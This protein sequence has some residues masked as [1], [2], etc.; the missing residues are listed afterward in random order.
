MSRV[1][2]P[3]AVLVCIVDNTRCP[4]KAD[5][6]ANSAVS[7]SLISP[8]IIVSGSCRKTDRRPLA[9][10]KPIFSLIPIW[11]APFISA[12]TGSSRQIN[13]VSSRLSMRNMAYKVAVLPLPVGPQISNKP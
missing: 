2:T 6:T 5:L 11:I 10:V 12:S 13:F 3:I 9:K 4:V 1:T 8:I 7:L